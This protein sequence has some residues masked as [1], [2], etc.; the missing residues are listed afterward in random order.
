MRNPAMKYYPVS[1]FWC[2]KEFEQ[3]NDTV[4]RQMANYGHSC[5]K[6]CF[7]KEQSF[8]DAQKARTD[9]RSHPHSDETRRLLSELRRGTDPW[10]KG[11]DISDDRVKKYV[12]GMKKAKQLN[13][14]I[15]AKN[16]N[17]KGGISAIKTPFP[18]SDRFNKWLDF[19]NAQ[20][21]KNGCRCY[22]CSRVLF[23]NELEIHHLL[24]Q[25][26][27]PEYI[28]E[29]RNCFVFCKNCHKQFHREFGKKNFTPADAVNFINR[30][31]IPGN[32]FKIAC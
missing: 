6:Q 3:R 16:S 15:V 28:F 1:C 7:G 13:P 12:A 8:R 22:K 20:I 4:K 21:S 32:H 2:K 27:Y 5:C 14:P 10:N 31:R 26:K 29:P 30:D 11:L 23:H 19:R 25:T 18:S 17:W 9:S 24:S